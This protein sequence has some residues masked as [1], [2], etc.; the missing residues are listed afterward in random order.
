M[1]L[2]VT[3]AEYDK[4]DFTKTNRAANLSILRKV[5]DV[6]GKTELLYNTERRAKKGI[7][8]LSENTISRICTLHYEPTKWDVEAVAKGL[9][10]DK[11]VFTGETLIMIK[12][13]ALKRFQDDYMKALK[14][15]QLKSKGNPQKLKMIKELSE[16]IPTE[17][18]LWV[19]ILRTGEEEETYQLVRDFKKILWMD[20]TKQVREEN[21]ED[22]QLWKYWNYLRTH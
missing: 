14:T 22:L 6:M 4:Y 3:K 16:V 20:L 15:E 13:E 7:L 17:E 5:A 8:N 21:F 1:G 12:G 2:Y 18:L 9:S 10:M 11:R 19:H